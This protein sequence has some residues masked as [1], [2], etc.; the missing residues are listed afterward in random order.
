M[1]ITN[2]SP[3]PRF[4]SYVGRTLKSGA[5]SPDIPLGVLLE[6][7]VW[8]DFDAGIVGIRLSEADKAMLARIAD[9]DK[10]PIKVKTVEPPPLKVAKPKPKTAKP[11]VPMN[12]DS[13]PIGQPDFGQA[14]PVVVPDAVKARLPDQPSL[15]DLKAVNDALKRSKLQ[16]IQAFTGSRV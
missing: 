16:N 11:G 4:F 12:K 6:S 1:R 2:T 15:N 3:N 14:T 13:V 9:V 7:L 10:Q 5:V 8:K